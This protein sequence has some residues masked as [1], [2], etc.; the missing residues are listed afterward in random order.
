M[1]TQWVEIRYR[2]F[3]DFPRAF[4]VERSG[5][6]LL[7]DCPFNDALDDYEAEFTVFQVKNEFRA[8]VDELS[9]QELRRYAT[10]VGVVPTEAVRFDETKRRAVNTE[11]FDLLKQH[12]G[13][14]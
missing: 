1:S 11:I 14:S 5:D 7:F 13:S 12:K 10:C 3:Y 2:D 6:L 9:W 8:K 4:V